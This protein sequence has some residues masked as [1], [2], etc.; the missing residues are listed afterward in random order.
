M[1]GQCN[2]VAPN[3][4]LP[5]AKSEHATQHIASVN[6]NSHVNI[7]T[8]SNTYKSIQPQIQIIINEIWSRHI[9]SQPPTPHPNAPNVSKEWYEREKC[10][11]FYVEMLIV[12][13]Y[14]YI[15]SFIFVMSFKWALK[16]L[17][18]HDYCPI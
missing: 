13:I 17:Y 8:G 2:I 5:L 11:K 9:F 1:I 18:I 14:I 6:A 15:G 4:K 10:L 16:Y 12:N 7:K 3:V